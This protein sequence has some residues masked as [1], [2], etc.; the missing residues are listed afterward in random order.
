M[1]WMFDPL[2]NKLRK[3]DSGEDVSFNW[4]YETPSGVVSWNSVQEWIDLHFQSIDPTIS[5]D[6][7]DNFWLYEV[8]D[9][10]VNPV[11]KARVTMG[12]NPVWTLTNIKYYRW[13][14]SWIMFAE[15]TT[16]SGGV[17][18]SETDTFTVTSEQRYTV[19]CLDS[20]WRT[21][22]ANW[23]YTFTLP[24]YG[25]SVSLTTMTKQTL[26]AESQSY[27]PITM[28]AEDDTDKQKFDYPASWT[29]IWWIQFY[30]TVS[31]AWEWLGGSKANSM[32]DWTETA[33][34][35][36]VQGNTVNYRRYTH[37]WAKIGS[38][39]LRFYK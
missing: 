11:I 8:W 31:S 21:A 7:D 29:V 10:R 34:T 12:Q 20:E 23:T 36:T 1:A 38:R 9:D 19:T 16:P 28:V 33:E 25:T 18:E 14:T 15:K 39:Q 13:T 37:S 24:T 2:L 32:N 35:H 30:N 5:I 26:R 27:F 17:W 6:W 22:T 4:Q 3:K